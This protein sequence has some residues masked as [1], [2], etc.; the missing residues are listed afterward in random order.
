MPLVA[1]GKYDFFLYWIMTT[2]EVGLQKIIPII[3]N[4]GRHDREYRK[5][6]TKIVLMKSG[7]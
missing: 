1:I 5:H 3:Q 4:D 2:M 6:G 7:E